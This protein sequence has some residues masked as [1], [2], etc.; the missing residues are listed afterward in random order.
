MPV[1]QAYKRQAER[2]SGILKA[3]YMTALAEM[4][5]VQPTSAVDVL[6]AM[7]EQADE[8]VSSLPIRAELAST[9]FS[10]RCPPE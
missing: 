9:G 4:R 10:V 1:K 8:N 3:A 6:D 2:Y 5:R 7:A